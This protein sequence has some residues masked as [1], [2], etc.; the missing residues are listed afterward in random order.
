MRAARSKFDSLVAQSWRVKQRQGDTAR[1]RPLD[2]DRLQAL[3][4]RYVGRYATSRAKLRG[5]LLRKIQD[6][7]WAGDAAPDVDALVARIAD[8]G[9]VD[10][11]AFAEA[12]A[13]SLGRRGYGVRRVSTA[14]RAAGIE[15]EDG[16]DALDV[17]REGAWAAAV[18]LARRRR[19]GPFAATPPDRAGLERAIA[20]LA[21]AGHDPRLARNVLTGN[22]E[23][24]DVD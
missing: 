8:L 1:R 5:Y 3:A 23:E 6:A 17:A 2:A 20:I 12:K 16:A 9:Y 18:A 24:T 10:D 19:L 14:L 4:L 15:G 7:E 22:G 11:R 21:R 13:A